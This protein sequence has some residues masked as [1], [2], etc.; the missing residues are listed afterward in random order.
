MRFSVRYEELDV[1]DLEISV[2]LQYTR[3]QLEERHEKCIEDE[4]IVD[5][6]RLRL[7][8]V[9]HHSLCNHEQEHSFKLVDAIANT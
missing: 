4:F 2:L 1:S 5:F 9:V 7:L 3:P 6:A 8:E